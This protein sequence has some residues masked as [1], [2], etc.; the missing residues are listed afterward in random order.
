MS[1]MW[2]HGGKGEE[3]D[4]EKEKLVEGRERERFESGSRDP[5][6]V[7]GVGGQG[8]EGVEG[9]GGEGRVEGGEG[10]GEGVSL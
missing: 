8:V 1:G 9:G 2:E 5:S 10:R 6:N 7:E 4:G 3:R